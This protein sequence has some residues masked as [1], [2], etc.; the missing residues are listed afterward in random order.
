MKGVVDRDA[1]YVDRHARFVRI[2]PFTNSNAQL[3]RLLASIPVLEAGYPP[4]T[5][6]RK[7]RAEYMRTLAAWQA[8]VGKATP[9]QTYSQCVKG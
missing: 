2:H 8:P 9:E 1:H 5:L 7:R 3:A 4:L 6:P